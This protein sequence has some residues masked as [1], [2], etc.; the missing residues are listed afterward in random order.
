MQLG[1]EKSGCREA[2][3]MSLNEREDVPP[4]G[5]E[6]MV[7]NE[8]RANVTQRVKSRCLSSEEQQLSLK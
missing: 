6:Q 8:R 2:S 5:A 1:V 4:G 3:Q 7:L